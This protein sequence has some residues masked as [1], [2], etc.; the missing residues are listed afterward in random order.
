M[1]LAPVLKLVR[2]Q[3]E[4]VQQ[5]RFDLSAGQGEF[6]G[7]RVRVAQEGELWRVGAGRSSDVHR[8]CVHARR[9]RDRHR[10]AVKDTAVGPSPLARADGDVLEGSA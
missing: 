7:L 10:S 1:A 5:L 6:G 8:S 3:R 2:D 9:R 4:G